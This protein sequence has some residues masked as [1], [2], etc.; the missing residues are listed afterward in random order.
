MSLIELDPENK[1]TYEA[2]LYQID[3]LGFEYDNGIHAPIRAKWIWRYYEYKI[4]HTQ[5]NVEFSDLQ[6]AFK[7]LE[8]TF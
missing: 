2:H 8:L 5:E 7:E 1:A 4:T 6:N 3:C